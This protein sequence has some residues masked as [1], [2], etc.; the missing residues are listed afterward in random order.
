MQEKHNPLE[1]GVTPKRFLEWRKPRF[2][3]SNPTKMTNNVW[4]WLIKTTIWPYSAAKSLGIEAPLNE[5]PTWCFSRFGQSITELPNG[6]QVYI[7]GE[8]EDYYDPDFNIYNDVVVINQ[9]GVVEIYGYPKEI[10]P[11][12]DFHSATLLDNE[13]IIIGSLG[14]SDARKIGQ[15]LVHRLNLKTYKIHPVNTTG[16]YPGWIFN[17]SAELSESGDYILISQ[18]DIYVENGLGKLEN[19]DKWKLNLSDWSWEKLTNKKYSIWTVRREDTSYLNLSDFRSTMIYSDNPLSKEFKEHTEELSQKIGRAV[20]FP[21]VSLINELYSPN[22]PH[23]KLPQDE[24]EPR[25]Y[26][27]ELNNVIVRYKEDLYEVRVLIEGELPEELSKK[28]KTDLLEKIG[29]LENAKCRLKE[30]STL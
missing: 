19:L 1:F 22:V 29:V 17:H 13:I 6:K 9:Y 8:H 3:T 27:I 26:E 21:F 28:L 11:P 14:Y 24:D 30:Y 23:V 5:G 25:I 4:E 16:A 2:G 15:T 7:G 10:F 12:T 18:G 20:D